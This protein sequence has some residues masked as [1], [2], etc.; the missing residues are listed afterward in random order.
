MKNTELSKHRKCQDEIRQSHS[1]GLLTKAVLSMHT[2]HHEREKGSV[3]SA[4]NN[5]CTGFV[6]LIL[7]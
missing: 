5:P 3:Q 4:K 2:H 7:F 1:Q 6:L